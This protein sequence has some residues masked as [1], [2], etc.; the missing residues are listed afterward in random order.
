MYDLGGVHIQYNLKDAERGYVHP[1]IDLNDRLETR[2]I[3]VS[4]THDI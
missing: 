2:M 4:A 1:L 3:P